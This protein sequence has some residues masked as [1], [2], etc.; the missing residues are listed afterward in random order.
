MTTGA[1]RR[2]NWARGAITSHEA[3]INR[4]AALAELL[5]QRLQQVQGLG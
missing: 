4:S 2:H 1:C 3:A 5:K